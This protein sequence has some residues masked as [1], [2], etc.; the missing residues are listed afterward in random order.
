MLLFV[1]PDYPR[2]CAGVQGRWVKIPWI[3]GYEMGTGLQGLGTGDW[4]SDATR[5]AA[6]FPCGQLYRPLRDRFPSLMSFVFG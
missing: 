3:K 6:G 2:V 1:P 5:I 4:G